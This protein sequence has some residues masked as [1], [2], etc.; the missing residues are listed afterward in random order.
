[1]AA[2]E[3]AMSIR[4]FTRTSP[5]SGK[6]RTISLDA[7]EDQWAAYD[8]GDLIQRALPHLSD[9]ERE[10]IMTGITDDEW[11]GAFGEDEDSAA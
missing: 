2:G 7:T 3:K 5:I 6:T 11:D 9:G 8:K 1:M 4:E 10:F